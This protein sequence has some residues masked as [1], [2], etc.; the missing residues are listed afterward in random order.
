MASWQPQL[1]SKTAI[2]TATIALSLSLLYLCGLLSFSIACK[3]CS[4]LPVLACGWNFI[5]KVT[6]SIYSTSHRIYWV[7]SILP[8]LKSKIQSKL[9]WER[10]HRFRMRGKTKLSSVRTK[11]KV[12]TCHPSLSVSHGGQARTVHLTFSSSCRPDVIYT[13]FVIRVAKSSV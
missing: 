13:L 10:F 2:F 11:T 1:C 7:L 12:M 3:K 8:A 4:L 9:R 6:N 5:S